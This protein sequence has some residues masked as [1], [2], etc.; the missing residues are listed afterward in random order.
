V[1]HAC[2]VSDAG[3]IRKTNEDGFV[4]DPELNLYAVADGMGG[5]RA[6]E[7]AS[8]LA[9]EAVAT[10]IRRSAHDTDF[11]WPYGIDDTL[12]FDG[13]RLRTAI[14]LA[15]RRV[16]RAAES[17]DDY[18]GMGTTIVGL[19]V[20]GAH[21]AIGYVGDSRLYL[22]AN[23][24]L[25][26]LTNDDSWAAAILAHDPGLT[27]DQLARHPMRNVLT[28]ALGARDQVDVHVSERAL[29]PGDVLLLCTDG[30]HG[31]L[32]AADLRRILA[33]T[34]EVE[35]AARALVTAAMDAGSRDNVTALVMRYEAD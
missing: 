18:S 12:S 14:H 21:T 4:A 29:T 16:F 26:Q 33:S 3:R 17:S 23:G 6:G 5:H 11:T 22:F 27:P 9:L 20:N 7:V 24:S 1:L 30:L 19:L 28:N 15:N 25:Q 32:D 2:G 31:A 35:Q 10:F 13:N 8:R 34:G